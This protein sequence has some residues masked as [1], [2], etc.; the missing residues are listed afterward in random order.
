MLFNSY[1]FLF[2]FFPISLL[3]FYFA[4]L[5]K[6]KK[7]IIITL[8]ISSLI[9]YGFHNTS[10]ILLLIFSIIVNYYVGFWLS[11]FNSIENKKN[12]ILL[13]VGIIFNISIL[14]IFKYF[15]FF[16]NNLS[17]IGINLPQA[18][19]LLPIGISFYT[20]QQIGFLVDIY[21]KKSKICNLIQY[22]TFVSFFP[23]L[24]AGPI[25][26]H[27]DFISQISS[28]KY[29]SIDYKKISLG[30]IIFIIGLFKKILIAD[31]IS[32]IFVEPFYQTLFNGEK[33]SALSS[34]I[35]TFSYSMQIYFDFSAYSEMAIGIGLL[36]G[37]TLPINFNSPFKSKSLIEYWNRWNITL[38][39]FITNYVYSPIFKKLSCN[40]SKFFNNHIKSIIAAM[41]ISGLWHGASW[42]FILW[43]L[44]HGLALAI[45]HYFKAKNLV[46]N[47]PIFFKRIFLI[48]F[49]NITFIIFKIKEIYLIKSTLISLIPYKQIFNINN[50]IGTEIYSRNSFFIFIIISLIVLFCPSSLSLLGYESINNKISIKNS[51]LNRYKINSFITLSLAFLISI[52]FLICI[53][54]LNRET[55]FIYF[56]F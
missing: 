24:I 23:Q 3:L 44:I 47:I 35:G 20:F 16:I 29:K 4:S 54:F 43:G 7:I 26:H 31:R 53:I 32:T 33:L 28:E 22:A 42:N 49:I 41:T 9:F 10:Y 11:R 21:K 15:N 30:I 19:I 25:V 34:W 39:Q 37:I 12:L 55:E 8:L 6:S 51:I 18:N 48:I 2:L 1:Q 46:K 40:S 50:V 17:L 36:F 45:N 14:F 13:K 5:T 38:T 56:Q 52:L 27:A